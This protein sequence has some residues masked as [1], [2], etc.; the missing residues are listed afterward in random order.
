[1]RVQQHRA[2]RRSGKRRDW[3][4]HETSL[5]DRLKKSRATFSA[6]T[7]AMLKIAGGEPS[8]QIVRFEK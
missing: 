8:L 6:S 2:R 7:N 4:A 5:T 3:A 1:M